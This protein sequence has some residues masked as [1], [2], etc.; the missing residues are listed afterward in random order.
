M[1]SEP[2]HG[3]TEV[4]IVGL[5]LRI[6]EHVTGEAREAL[7]QC[8]RI[9]AIVQERP[10]LWLNSSDPN[11]TE[12]INL[13]SL[14]TENAVRKDNYDRATETILSAAK[15]SGPI[16]YVTYGNPM[17]YDSVAQSLVLR[18]KEL[19]LRIKVLPGISSIDTLLCDLGLDLAPG[20]QICEA[21][22][23]V[24]AG[25]IPQPSYALL[26]VQIGMFGS[27]RTHY[28]TLPNPKSL[29]SLSA[30]LI[31][32]YPRTHSVFLVRSAGGRESVAR[33]REVQLGKISEVE[34]ECILNASL[35]VPAVQEA[36]IDEGMLKRM[37]SM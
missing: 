15:D 14:Y 26:L 29:D 12:V 24:A 11:R 10:D 25:I 23:M 34:V 4:Y 3:G 9:Y 6:P 18:G 30:Y 35:F 13:L 17:A 27:L 19:G 22:W 1:P 31:R 33:I 7:S 32:F 20:I 5:G 2:M 8:S 28:Q 16:G 37:L 36:T 21:S